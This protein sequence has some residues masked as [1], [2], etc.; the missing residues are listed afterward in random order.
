MRP[1]KY[2]E[3]VRKAQ[4]LNDRLA[5]QRRSPEWQALSGRWEQLHGALAQL[6]QSPPL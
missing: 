6:L 4:E 3:R 1:M 2:E 5:F